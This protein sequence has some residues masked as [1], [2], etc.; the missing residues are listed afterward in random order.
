MAWNDTVILFGKEVGISSIHGFGEHALDL[1]REQIAALG[2]DLPK[3]VEWFMNEG[4]EWCL[5]RDWGHASYD[6]Q[7]FTGDELAVIYNS[8]YADDYDKWRCFN[9]PPPT[10][11]EER[12]RKPKKPG[13]VYLIRADNGYY[14]IGRTVNPAARLETLEVRLPFPI[15]ALHI[16]SCQDMT[17]TEKELHAKFQDKRKDGEWFALTDEDVEYIKSL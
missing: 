17:G 15:E 5:V 6:R 9:D 4:R 12:R 10:P 14:K 11:R 1:T 13:Y 7:F 16:V 8:K 3:V 2:D